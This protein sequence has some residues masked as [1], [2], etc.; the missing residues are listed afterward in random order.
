[1]ATLTTGRKEIPCKGVGGIKTVYLFPYVDYAYTLIAGTRG[2]VLTSFPATDIYE[3]ETV[4]ASM[5]ETGKHEE[6][7]LS[8]DQSLTF[9]LKKQDK[10]TTNE[11]NI[12]TNMELSYIVKFNDGRFKIGGL[13]NGASL[14]FDGDSGG[15]KES[16]NGYNIKIEGLEEWQGAFIDNLSS[17]GFTEKQF[18]LLTDGDAFL[19]EDGSKLILN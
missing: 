14:S 2:K 5:T 18:L 19:M 17:A 7:G 13:Y 12:M 16:F 9:T 15:G 4:R 10:V 11:L 3:F 6:D 1:M 8:Y